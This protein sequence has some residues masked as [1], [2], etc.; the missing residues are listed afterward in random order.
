[1]A[2]SSKAKKQR[3]GVATKKQGTS[4]SEAN[5]LDLA[6]ILAND[7]QRKVFTEH[8]LGRPI[9]APKFSK[10][11][12]DLCKQMALGETDKNIDILV[13][14]NLNLKDRM[15]H[16]YLS[17][18]IMPKFSNHSQIN[19]IELQLVYDL[20]HNLEINWALKLMRH[21]WSVRE[22]NSLLP[23]AII[24]SKILEHF[25][26]SMAGESKITLNARDS[27]IDVDMIHKMGFFRDLND[28]MYKHRSDRPAA[29]PEPQPSTFQSK[30]S[31]SS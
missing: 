17:Y 7:E 16:Y 19:D 9:F 21:M 15:L 14:G 5:S 22:T 12:I 3:T 2:S 6:R 1:M 30:S 31:S 24:I 26:V 23:Y 10:E 25:G 18:V 4:S 11:E 27:K 13:V 8:F 29:P 20:K 28:R